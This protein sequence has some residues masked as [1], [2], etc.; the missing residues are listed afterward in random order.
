[1]YFCRMQHPGAVQHARCRLSLIDGRRIRNNRERRRGGVLP[2]LTDLVGD[3]SFEK[4]GPGWDT[5]V[6]AELMGSHAGA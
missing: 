5:A 2:E 3:G 6:T 4:D 1:M